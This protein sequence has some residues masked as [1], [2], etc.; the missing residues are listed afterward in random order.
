MKHGICVSARSLFRPPSPW[1]RIW[2]QQGPAKHILPLPHPSSLPPSWSCLLATVP[3]QDLGCAG[4]DVTLSLH[5]S[6]CHLESN[7]KVVN[8][9]GT[10][11]A[12]ARGAMVEHPCDAS[13]WVAAG[14]TASSL[15]LIPA[16][17]TIRAAIR[18]ELKDN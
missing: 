18:E 9:P 1:G 11:W 17:V 10:G 4:R 6:F 2:P 5:Q 16:T 3:G 13:A 15:T 8:P 14:C 12:E 7:G